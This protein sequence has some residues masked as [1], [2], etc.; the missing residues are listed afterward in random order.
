MLYLVLILGLIVSAGA[1]AGVS[2]ADSVQILN[3]TKSKLGYTCLFIFTIAYIVVILEEYTDMR[4]SKPVLLA[5]GVIWALIAFAY[6]QK[7][8]T[9]LWVT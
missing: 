4:K 2:Q 6:S 7:A 8:Y 3:L 5:A 9:R 1:W